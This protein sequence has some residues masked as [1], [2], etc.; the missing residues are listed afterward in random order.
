MKDRRPLISVV[1]AVYN[2]ERSIGRCIDSVFTQDIAQKELII[3]DG[4]SKDGT[5]GILKSNTDKIAYWISE[6][7]RGI[8]HALNKG[9]EKARGEWI[10]FL[11]ADDYFTDNRLLSRLSPVL[12]SAYPG[13]RVVYGK[14]ALVDKDGK[15]IASLGRPWEKAGRAFMSE[16]TIP[17][18][19]V[20]H[21]RSLFE[22]R[23]GF[24][25]SYRI[26]GDY[27]L[28]LRELKETAPLFV[29]MTVAAMEQGGLSSTA[30]NS[31][32][33]LSEFLRARKKNGVTGVSAQWLWLYFK[34]W[35][36]TGLSALKGQPPRAASGPV[37]AFPGKDK[38][39]R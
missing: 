21:H 3:I 35:V 28:L 18:Q 36:K 20:F 38:E 5:V 8:Y 37:R 27:E 17:H 13:A 14:V 11:G 25:E 10:F 30:S 26:A 32:K 4:G 39:R 16:M 19:G 7:D 6:S 31:V 1:V 22:L 2:G 12:H 34:G 33:T 29:D 15:T 24:D 23:G 9:V